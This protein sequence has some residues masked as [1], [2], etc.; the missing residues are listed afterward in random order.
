[1]FWEKLVPGGAGEDDHIWR[2]QGRQMW[3]VRVEAAHEALGSEDLS[4]AEERLGCSC[5]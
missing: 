2:S 3:H 1:M 5:P 4:V